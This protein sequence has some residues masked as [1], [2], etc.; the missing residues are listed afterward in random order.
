M[1]TES[2]DPECRRKLNTG[3]GTVLVGLV[4]EQDAEAEQV[5]VG[6]AVHLSFGVS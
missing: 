6:A 1:H 3:S 2:K 4:G 5:G